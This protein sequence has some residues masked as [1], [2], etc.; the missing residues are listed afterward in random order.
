MRDLDKVKSTPSTPNSNDRLK[1][2]KIT[3]KSTTTTTT[4]MLAK[5]NPALKSKQYQPNLPNPYR[6]NPV[7]KQKDSNKQENRKGENIGK[8][9]PKLEPKVVI[10]QKL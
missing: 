7:I 4:R 1:K 10:K 8:T 5:M 2:G 3:K 6:F 9:A